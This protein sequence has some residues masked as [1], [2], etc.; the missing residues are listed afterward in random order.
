MRNHS[1]YYTTAYIYV[2]FMF[3]VRP[4]PKQ[5]F[6][7]QPTRINYF[8]LVKG[9]KRRM[10]TVIR[11]IFLLKEYTKEY[12]RNDG[13]GNCTCCLFFLPALVLRKNE[14]IISTKTLQN[15]TKYFI[16][17]RNFRH[18]VRKRCLVDYFFS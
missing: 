4:F 2:F 12:A 5:T 15:I 16:I 14:A 17:K 3:F 1:P 9:R 18:V 6:Q 13:V 10:E 7:T 11:N 8:V